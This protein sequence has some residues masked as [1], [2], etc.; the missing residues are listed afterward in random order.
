VVEY[1]F[2]FMLFLFFF[3]VGVW[4][5]VLLRNRVPYDGTLVIKKDNDGK[6][7]FLL[8]IDTDPYELR[9]KDIISFKV[10]GEDE[11]DED[12]I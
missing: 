10:A 8:E 4:I 7:T 1:V 3:A 6:Q 9:D 5:G 12:D 2:L 11:S